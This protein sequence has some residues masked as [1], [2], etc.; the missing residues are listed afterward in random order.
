MPS[1]RPVLVPNPKLA[2]GLSGL[3]LPSCTCLS[4]HDHVHLPLPDWDATSLSNQ[5]SPGPPMTSHA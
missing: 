1:R 4:H 2:P 5:A 3:L